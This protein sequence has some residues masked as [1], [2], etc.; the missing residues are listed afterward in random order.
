MQPF[1]NLS[2]K[3]SIFLFSRE[4]TVIL[5][6]VLSGL[7]ALEMSTSYGVLELIS[8]DGIGVPNKPGACLHGTGPDPANWHQFLPDKS[9]ILSGVD[10]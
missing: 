9:L 6:A 10:E 4:D 3:S 5:S 1:C 8:G 2:D 7:S